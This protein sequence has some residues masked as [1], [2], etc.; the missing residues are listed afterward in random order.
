MIHPAI[1]PAIAR[2]ETQDGT[3]VGQATLIG[4]SLCVT[5]AHVVAEAL[6]EP[7]ALAQAPQMPVALRFPNCNGVETTARVVAWRPF[8]LPLAAGSDL[9]LLEVDWPDGAAPPPVPL[10]DESVAVP[11]QDV[12]LLEYG[13][14]DPCGDERMG[15][16]LAT[17]GVKLQIEGARFIEPGVSGAPVVLPS[18]ARGLLGIAAGRPTTP[19]PNAHGYAIPARHI[20]ALLEEQASRLAQEKALAAAEARA[21]LAA[22][23]GIVE[24]LRAGV[25]TLKRDNTTQQIGD[26]VEGALDLVAAE[27]LDA[28]SKPLI[29]AV[30]TLAKALD[31]AARDCRDVVLRGRRPG[32]GDL[33]AID[34]FAPFGIGRIAAAL[35]AIDAA[36]RRAPRGLIPNDVM[37]DDSA[38]S[39]TSELRRTIADEVARL[40][41][42]QGAAEPVRALKRLDVRLRPKWLDPVDLRRSQQEIDALPLPFRGRRG[43]GGIIGAYVHLADDFSVFKDVDAPWCP[44]MVVIPAGEFVMG[45][46]SGEAERSRNEGPQHRVTIGYRF[47][48]GRYAVTFDE[49]DHFCA[50]TRREKPKDQGWG[51]GRRPVINVIWRD[52]VA[53][54]E[55][56]S[57]R[58]GQRYRL[59]S[60]AEWEY[61]CRAGTTTPFSFGATIG[62]E[63][64]NHDGNHPYGSGEK[65]VYRRKTIPVGSLPANPWG[66][67]EMHGNVSEWVEDA[68]HASYE[69]A[70]VDGSA[71]LEK[72]AGADR[73]VRGGSWFD[74]ARYVRSAF[75]ARLA[76]VVR[77]D[78]LGFRCARVQES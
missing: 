49:Y 24:Q 33:P 48:L 13:A 37:E 28:P 16:W 74:G 44:E 57:E 30:A 58:T 70:P 18:P 63:Q 27:D 1:K 25:G 55:W 8:A 29:A 34:A 12:V 59:P 72:S 31:D 64:V 69:G 75:R 38:Y 6:G 10:E 19:G 52:A 66:L 71:W 22:L 68:W 23:A 14:A 11:P 60:E 35:A 76:P 53:Y 78:N 73:V 40:E 2:V 54:C 65:G 5:C 41:K 43:L 17:S 67:H 21:P 45:S 36:E 56:L 47:A 9:A 7:W 42:D 3:H 77:L 61:A 50:A 15:R 39:R 32:G 51:R 4:A 46:P 20:A 26:A 62:A